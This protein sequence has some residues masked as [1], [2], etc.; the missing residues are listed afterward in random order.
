MQTAMTPELNAATFAAILTALLW[1]PHILQRIIE[2]GPYAALRDPRHDEPTRAPWAQRAIRAHTNAVE[3]LAVF[4][5]LAIAIHVLGAGTQATATAAMIYVAARLAHYLFYV[6][7]TPWLRT[8]MFLIGFVEK[9]GTAYR[10]VP[11]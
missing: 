7:G 1:A 3:N 9:A 8:P 10:F 2:M 5:T 4:A 11:G 6:L